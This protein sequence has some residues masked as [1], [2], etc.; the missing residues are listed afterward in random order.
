MRKSLTHVI[1]I[2]NNMKTESLKLPLKSLLNKI[3]SST[4]CPPCLMLTLK[5][6]VTM[7]IVNVP[8]RICRNRVYTNGDGQTKNQLEIQR[9]MIL[10]HTFLF[11][12]QNGLKESIRMMHNQPNVV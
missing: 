9:H 4:I 11:C 3:V 5:S 8:T 1:L 12:G 2:V 10:R 7:K 6:V